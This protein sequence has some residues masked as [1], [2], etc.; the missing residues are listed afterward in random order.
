MKTKFIVLVIL[1]ASMMHVQ[2]M[3][4]P[5]SD[6][7]RPRG[8]SPSRAV[9]RGGGSEGGSPVQRWM[10]ELQQ[11]D[12]ETF[13]RLQQ[14][15]VEN[16]EQFRQEARAAMT[17]RAMQN[18]Q[19]ERPNIYKAVME[20]PDEDKD[21][22]VNRLSRLHSFLPPPPPPDDMDAEEAASPR[23]RDQYRRLIRSYHQ[24]EN[25]EEKHQIRNAIRKQLE[26]DYDNRLQNR[27][28]QIQEMEQKLVQIRRALDAGSTDKERFI[29][30]KLSVWL[31]R[32]PPPRREDRR[33]LGPGRD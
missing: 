14:L 26:A 20:L 7:D 31:D 17:Q 5:D 4:Q 24:T 18:L 6:Y 16:P 1:L 19:R 33:R 15:R 12:P 32:E 25:A 22:L 27:T 30:E 3:A 2:V 21:W 28:H 8:S 23:E 9:W 10:R 13:T 11:Q 29:E